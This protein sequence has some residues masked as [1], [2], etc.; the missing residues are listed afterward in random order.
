MR[1]DPIIEPLMQSSKLPVYL[2]ALN[3]FY[4]SEK[5]KRDEFHAW[6][7][8]NMK[9]E[10]IN[11]DVV[12]HSPARNKHIDVTRRLTILLSTHAALHDLGTV[13]TEKAL[14]K[15]TRNSFEPDICY[16]NKEKSAS[17]TDGT[18]FFPAPDFV[19]E[20][21]SESTEK[22]DR[23]VKMEDYALHGVGEYWLI[24]TD[25]EV[26]EQYFLQKGA[27]VQQPQLGGTISSMVVGGFRIVPDEVFREKENL[28]ALQALF[29]RQGKNEN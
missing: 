25:K 4:A 1:V 29:D 12:V 21:L 27:F 17:F 15:L 24:D 7:T 13:K 11:G 20:V 22:T 14:V 16:F 28:A 23:T 3:A 26:I 19:V 6:L 5:K 8:P 9:A 18:L 10:F 2:E